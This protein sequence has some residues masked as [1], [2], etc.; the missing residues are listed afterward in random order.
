MILSQD[1]PQTAPLCS[2]QDPFLTQTLCICRLII[3]CREE[4]RIYRESI[5]TSRSLP[6]ILFIGPFE[7]LTTIPGKADQGRTHPLKINPKVNPFEV[8]ETHLLIIKP[9]LETCGGPKLGL[10]QERQVNIVRRFTISIYSGKTGLLSASKS[11]VPV[12]HTF[13]SGYRNQ[14]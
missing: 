5:H 11:E 7:S 3:I 2:L 4:Y 6:I 8:L 9:S 13:Y 1:T 12:E 10:R 14:Q